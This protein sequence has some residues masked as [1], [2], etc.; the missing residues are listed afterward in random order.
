MKIVSIKYLLVNKPVSL[1]GRRPVSC[2]YAT[3]ACDAMWAPRLAPT[4]SILFEDR[5]RK[6]RLAKNSPSSSPRGFVTRAALE[7]DTFTLLYTFC[8]YLSTYNQQVT[9]NTRSS[10]LSVSRKSVEVKCRST[11]RRTPSCY[12]KC[13]SLN[14]RRW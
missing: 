2:L 5:P 11:L 10:H 7:K 12:H 14:G 6:V 3:A 1:A 13:N 8:R 9:S 4:S